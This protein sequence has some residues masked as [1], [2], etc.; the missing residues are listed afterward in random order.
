M[1]ITRIVPILSL[2]EHYLCCVYLCKIL[3][4]V[5]EYPKQRANRN[6]SND[7]KLIETKLGELETKRKNR[8]QCFS[9]ALNALK[10]EI[11]R[12]KRAA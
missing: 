6:L 7:I 1:N 9:N 12:H 8:L 4:F 3:G 5:R 10:E 11:G 2:T